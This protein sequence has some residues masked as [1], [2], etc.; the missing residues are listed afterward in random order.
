M[1]AHIR[2]I[3]PDGEP[4]GEWE[5]NGY[6]HMPL[7]DQA[8]VSRPNP[9]PPDEA[10]Y[11]ISQR[12]ARLAAGTT[13]EDHDATLEAERELALHEP[14]AVDDEIVRDSD[15]QALAYMKAWT[16]YE[17]AYNAVQHRAMIDNYVQDLVRL[18]GAIMG[19]PE[20]KTK[21]V[22]FD[23]EDI[24]LGRM[25]WEAGQERARLLEWAG[26]MAERVD[27]AA[28]A[29]KAIWLIARALRINPAPKDPEEFAEAVIAAFKAGYRGYRITTTDEGEKQ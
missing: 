24:N 15:R 21:E 26:K 7:G 1:T 13:K 28:R 12:A 11:Y 20:E 18:I 27:A 17:C 6:G 5:T 29:E 3:G 22:F 25:V 14:Y 10:A 2:A 4:L 8:E 23:G 9:M 16:H 19:I